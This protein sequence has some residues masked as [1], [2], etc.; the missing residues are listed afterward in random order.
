MSISKGDQG[1]LDP[2]FIWTLLNIKTPL[3]VVN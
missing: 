2:V 1:P 3:Q